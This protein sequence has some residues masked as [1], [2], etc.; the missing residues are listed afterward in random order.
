MAISG[1]DVSYH[2]GNINWKTVSKFIDFAIIRA[3]FGKNNIDE[4]AV[5]NIKGCEANNIPYG[6]FWFS[7]ALSPEMA[8]NEADY[9]C[10]FADKYS[11]QYPICYD[12]EYDSDSY[13]SN[14]SCKLK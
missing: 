13:A 1:I 14:S 4:K 2:N 9:I 6:L 11:P 7:Y 8:K 3:G 12:W 5:Q 10:N